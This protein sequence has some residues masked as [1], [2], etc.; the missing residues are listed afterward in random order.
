MRFPPAFDTLC[1]GLTLKPYHYTI[2]FPLSQ[3]FFNFYIK[4]IIQNQKT[5]TKNMQQYWKHLNWILSLSLLSGCSICETPKKQFN[6]YLPPSFREIEVEVPQHSE[7][8]SAPIDGVWDTS[9]VDI[10]YINPERKLIAFT[11]D[12]GPSKTMESLL[13][14]FAE[15]NEKSPDC[16][17]TATFFLNGQHVTEES[18]P[19][20]HTALLLG[21]ELGNHT[22]HHCD[23]TKIP[24]EDVQTEIEQTDALLSKIDGKQR[25]LLRPPFG[26]INAEIK[27]SLSVPVINWTIDTLDWT[28]ISEDTIYEHVF[29][30]RFS[31]AIVL[32]H[33]GYHATVNALKKL[34]PDLKADGYQ[35]VSISALAKAHSCVLRNGKEYVRARKQIK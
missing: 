26:L 28:G 31:G 8:K 2:L 35:V 20:L 23:L 13:A 33:D 14:L 10:S 29:S 18:T 34:L 5:N 27:K 16:R 15:Y 9:D 22:H 19:L 21:C 30:A 12:D 24:L 11:F 3:A 7:I 4:C 17:A 25:H 32:M 6:T 1:L